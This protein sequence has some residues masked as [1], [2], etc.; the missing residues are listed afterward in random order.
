MALISQSQADFEDFR[1]KFWGV[2]WLICF[3]EGEI[4]S[5]HLFELRISFTLPQ[6]FQKVVITEKW[7]GGPPD[8]LCFLP[9]CT[10]RGP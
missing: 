5:H 9:T 2:C 4:F 10:H 3:C 8:S 1:F 6:S 7:S